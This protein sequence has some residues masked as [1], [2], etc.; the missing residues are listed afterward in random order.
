MSWLAQ[1]FNTVNLAQQQIAYDIYRQ[2]EYASVP[3]QNNNPFA[4]SSVGSGG[5]SSSASWGQA[6]LDPV[7]EFIAGI[8]YQAIVVN[9]LNPLIAM[10]PAPESAKNSW[11]SGWSVYEVDST[12]FT[13]GRIIGGV[14][15]IIQGAWEIAS[16][17]AT[18]TGGT[19]ISCGTGVLCFGGGAASIVAGTALVTHGSVVLAN[20]AYHTGQQIQ[21]LLSSSNGGGGNGGES[22]VVNK[23]AL[24]H[25]F[26]RHTIKGTK[27]SESSIFFNKNDIPNLLRDAEKVK[28]VSQSSTRFERIVDAGRI[29]GIDASTGETT[30]I[31]TVITD[32]H[33]NLITMFPG[34]P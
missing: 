31:Y 24:S 3:I 1:G 13:L 23:D 29:I 20:S 5:T 22:I 2:G 25:I 28:P 9:N 34:L 33:G 21:A 7:A 30:S 16:G 26:D 11:F 6:I 10:M 15:G 18:A 4:N 19:L 32:Q 8:G 14:L 12:A 17:I 27:N